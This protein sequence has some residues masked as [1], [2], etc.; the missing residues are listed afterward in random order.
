MAH[1]QGGVVLAAPVLD[2]VY[3]GGANCNSRSLWD[4]ST[5][6]DIEVTGEA[7]TMISTTAPLIL[8][9]DTLRLG[10]QAGKAGERPPI[11]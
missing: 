11:E 6:N 9:T 1:H 3:Y 5:G 2:G 7:F 8:D 4:A 10:W